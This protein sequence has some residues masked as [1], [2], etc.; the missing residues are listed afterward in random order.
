MSP[1]N[2]RPT[3][4]YIDRSGFTLIE[5]LVAFVVLTTLLSVMYRSVVVTRA[6]ANAFDARTQGELVA[7]AV[8][9]EFLAR[10]D[11][12]NGSYSGERDG[13]NWT[14]TARPLDL[15]AQLPPLPPPPQLPPG[16]PAA[17]AGPNAAQKPRWVPQRIVVRVATSGRPLQIE[18]VHLVATEPPQ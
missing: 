12:H 8:F 7:R 9:A 18:A 2:S 6:G 13:R 11:L 17:G 1:L 10:R 4:R 14:L 3:G 5:V 15:A 16:S